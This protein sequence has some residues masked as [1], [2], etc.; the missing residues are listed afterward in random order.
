MT[1]LFRSEDRE[2]ISSLA[3]AVGFTAG[4][5]LETTL[6]AVV[7]AINGNVRYTFIDGHTPVA[8]TTGLRLLKDQVIEVWGADDMKNFLAI[9]DGGTAQLEVVYM[10]TG[11]H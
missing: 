3:S 7:Q 5:L 10:G 11:A 6:Y 1:S 2:T 8:A 9:D 4:K